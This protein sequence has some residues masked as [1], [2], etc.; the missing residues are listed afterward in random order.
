MP[1]SDPD[2]PALGGEPFPLDPALIEKRGEF[3]EHSDE[4]QPRLT[5]EEARARAALRLITWMI[6]HG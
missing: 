1:R 3:P 2:H 5:G 6:E 4:P